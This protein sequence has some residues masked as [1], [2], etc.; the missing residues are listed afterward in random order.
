[1][2]RRLLVEGGDKAVSFSAI[3]QA[4]GLAAPTLVQRYGSR[5]GMVHAAL[6]DGWEVLTRRTADAAAEAPVSAK[7]IPTLLKLV[8]RGAEAEIALLVGTAREADLRAR[9]EGWREQLEAALA[10]RLGAGKKDD[11]AP[12][13]FSAWLGRLLWS[14]PGGAG[15]RLKDAVRRLG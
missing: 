8:G 4:S 5:D 2:T 15:F 10:L 13:I 11:S 6:L 14:G 7:G 9:A 3:A 12:L 1:M